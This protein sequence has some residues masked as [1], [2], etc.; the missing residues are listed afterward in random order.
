MASN[1]GSILSPYFPAAGTKAVL[2]IVSCTVGF[3]IVILFI[4][5]ALLTDAG[6][7]ASWITPSNATDTYLLWWYSRCSDEPL[8]SQAVPRDM[9]SRGGPNIR[10]LKTPT[11]RF[12][13]LFAT[14]AHTAPE[15]GTNIRG[16]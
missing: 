12:E 1:Q 15:E 7:N 10:S 11:N 9:V 6:E 4:N 3:F 13:D 2:T 14:G 16:A 5:R 8:L